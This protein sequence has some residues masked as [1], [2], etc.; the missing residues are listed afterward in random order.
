MSAL[1]IC[2][3][4][5]TA[6]GESSPDEPGED[7]SA[8]DST[9][10]SAADSGGDMAQ[11]HCE[12][13][14]AAGPTPVTVTA[15]D[16]EVCF[17]GNPPGPDAIVFDLPQPD[18]ACCAERPPAFFKAWETVPA[19]TLS[20]EL[21]TSNSK[22]GGFIPYEDGQ[23][24]HIVHGKQGGIHVDAAV[25]VVLPAEE[26][27][28]VKLQVLATGHFECKETAAGNSPTIWVRPD[29]D[30][31]HGYTNAST[32]QP[33]V[34]VRFPVAGGLWYRYCGIWMELGV[35]V[36]IPASQQWGRSVR[37]VRLYDGVK[38]PAAGR[39]GAP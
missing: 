18:P 30:L 8:A 14:Y 38:T 11:A 3:M 33:G 29:A 24:L 32:T 21:G 20:V 6:C 34:E 39:A 4:G 15:V 17:R 28:K 16:P 36:R 25:R 23:W 12:L 2:L 26:A 37:M 35:A 31:D 9:A 13:P 7:D 5:L 22:T 27:P 10:D 1:A 19:P